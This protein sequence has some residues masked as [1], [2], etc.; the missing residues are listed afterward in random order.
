MTII[1]AVALGWDEAIC[2]ADSDVYSRGEVLRQCNKLVVSPLA[3]IIGAGTGDAAIMEVGDRA[4]LDAEDV[5]DL[6]QFLPGRLLRAAAKATDRTS[7]RP[8]DLLRTTYMATGFSRSAGRV[9]VHV[10]DAFGLFEPRVATRAAAPAVEFAYDA[11]SGVKS[12]IPIARAQM[13]IMRETTPKAAGSLCVAHLGPDGISCAAIYDFANETPIEPRA[14]TVHEILSA[15]SRG[16]ADGDAEGGRVSIPAPP[17]AHPIL[18]E[19][20]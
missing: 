20:P 11:I 14:R 5:D 16:A 13:G 18:E 3:G 17:E 12:V 19:V 1:G 4:V 10:F 9:L 7:R 15:R 6:A 2:W 8:A